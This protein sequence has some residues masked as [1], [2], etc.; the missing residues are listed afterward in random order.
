MALHE[1]TKVGVLLPTRESVMYDEG[2]GDPRP[3]VA[4]AQQAEALGYDSVWAGDSLLAKPRAEPLTLLA[5]VAAAT[6]RVELGTAVLIASQRNPE[7]LAHGCATVDALAGGRFILGV[8]A[9]PGADNVRRDHELVGADFARRSSRSI[10]VVE[11]CRSLWTGA[12]GDQIYPLPGRA[13]GPPVWVGGAGP[14]TLER[15]GR[16]ADG[17]F[18]ISPTVE[19]FADGLAAVRSAAEDADRDP[20]ELDVCIYSTVVIGEQDQAQAE[21]AE[22]LELYYRAPF[23]AIRKVQGVCAGSAAR[24]GEFV[25]SF[26]DAGAN[27]VCVRFATRDV[28]GQMEAFT[29]LLP[30]LRS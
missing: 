8:G 14:R 9:G 13:G 11:R 7:Q 21:L 24:V 15:T 17:W 1:G 28:A 5:G 20:D 19:A 22:H 27:H 3:L 12:D 23:E 29:E 30:E 26:V 4:L 6:E 2:S 18:P 16:L 25:Q 10:E